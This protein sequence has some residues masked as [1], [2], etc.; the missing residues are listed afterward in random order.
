MG[1]RSRIEA[2]D[3]APGLLGEVRPEIVE[4]VALARRQKPSL[5]FSR[6]IQRT[7]K[8]GMIETTPAANQIMVSVEL[9]P[10]GRTDMFR[11]GIH[12]LRPAIRPGALGLFD[13]R[14]PWSADVKDPFD[15]VNL[16][17]PFGAFD[18]LAEE[19]GGKF[20][21][22][23]L[24]VNHDNHDEVMHHL[25]QAL[26]PALARPHEV[27]TLFLDHMFLAIRDHLAFT[28]GVFS[29]KSAP[30]PA[31]GPS[32]A[33]SRGA[34][35][36]L[37]QSRVVERFCDDLSF[38]PGLSEMAAL[39]GLSRSY[40]AEAFKRTFGSPPHRW[41]LRQRVN[42]ARELLQHSTKPVSE[43]ALECGFADQSHLT[44]VFSKEFGLGPGA[45]GGPIC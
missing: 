3:R 4:S 6:F 32:N 7:A 11:D 10:R 41:L 23:D 39:C 34:L 13:M 27:N 45:G 25:A 12:F 14:V 29:G 40:F 24:N 2:G 37:Q 44:R 16:F 36:A 5:F 35:T 20:L 15:N 43:I 28:Y 9:D 18:E 26:L 30:G 38:D 31:R 33:R 17:L 1:V 8:L 21:N 42:R 22:V 19:K